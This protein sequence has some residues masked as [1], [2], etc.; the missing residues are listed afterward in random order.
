MAVV[1]ANVPVWLRITRNAPGIM[2][3]RDRGRNRVNADFLAWKDGELVGDQRVMGWLCT[4]EMMARKNRVSMNT[5]AARDL[6]AANED[7]CRWLVDFGPP[8]RLRAAMTGALVYA[9]P[10]FPEQT[11]TFLERFIAGTDLPSGSPILAL[12]KLP[13]INA[14]PAWPI[15]L[16]SAYKTLYALRAFIKKK[17]VQKFEAPEAAY[18]FFRQ[19]REKAG[20]SDQ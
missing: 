4:I 10:V 1:E 6:L 11:N 2:A 8:R 13:H 19:E 20:I 5:K 14:E 3:I 7:G 18:D 12:S 15:R 16:E 17:Q 9:Y